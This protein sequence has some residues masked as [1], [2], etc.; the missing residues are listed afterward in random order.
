MVI[1]KLHLDPYMDLYNREII[2]Y[3]ISPKPSAANIV[4]TLYGA[5]KIINDCKYRQTCHSDQGW[6]YQMK[7]YTFALKE[8]RNYQRMSIK[9]NCYDNSV[10]ENFFGIMK[11][12]MYYGVVYYYYEELKVAI[13]TYT[14]YYN[15]KRIKE[16]LGWM[17]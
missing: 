13:V 14:S 16:K 9:G 4:D 12:E 7:A 1:K 11:Q 6:G 8:N 2:S 5:I 17:S 10:I 15:E 3:G